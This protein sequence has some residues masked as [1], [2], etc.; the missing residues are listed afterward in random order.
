MEAIKLIIAVDD[1]LFRKDLCKIIGSEPGFDATEA[2]SW[3][4]LEKL[5]SKISPNV[6]LA[7]WRLCLHCD[8]AIISNYNREHYLLVI[9]EEDP[10]EC[11]IEAMKAG[12]RGI[13]MRNA[14]KS[15]LLT[16][17]HA[18]SSGAYLFCKETSKTLLKSL[19]PIP[20]EEERKDEDSSISKREKDILRYISN[21]FTNSEIA[22]KLF[23]SA[24]TVATHRRN[25]LQKI[26]A[27]NTAALVRYAS[28][29]GLL[30]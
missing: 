5:S 25:L 28:K 10:E 22:E 19:L 18:V 21:G 7:N 16:A 27:K 6:I 4:E 15:D 23:I 24:H 12:A 2:A 1:Y 11:L 17:I 8:V 14:S 30:T 3:K 9:A 20:A 13:I 29:H 26:N